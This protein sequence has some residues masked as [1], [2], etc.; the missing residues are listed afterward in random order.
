MVRETDPIGW[1]LL[2]AELEGIVQRGRETARRISA[3]PV[4]REM[5]ECVFALFTPTGQSVCYSEGL[6]LH[7]TSMGGAI[8]FMVENDYDAKVGIRPG[9]L[10]FNND[11]YISGAHSPDQMILTP[12]FA[13][14]ELIGWAGG[15]THVPEVGASEPGG[16]GSAS[17]SRYDEGIFMPCVKIGQDDQL[18]FDLE[19]LVERGTR[20]STWWLL[21]NRAKVAGITAIRDDLL[22]TIEKHGLE[23]YREATA[24]YIEATRDACRN[25]VRTMLEPGTYRAVAFYDVPWGDKPVRPQNDYL[26]RFAV[27]MVVNGD[28]TMAIDFEGTSAAG[29]HPSNCTPS[30]VRGLIVTVLMTSLFYDLNAN[31]GLEDYFASALKIPPSVLNPPDFSYATGYW[32]GVVP[33]MSAFRDC[34]T[35]AI[36]ARGYREECAGAYGI[37]CGL[38]TGGT[39]Q[40]GKTFSVRQFESACLGLPATA[41]SDGVDACFAIFN[42]N[43][44][45]S[46]A[47]VWEKLIPQMF[48]G[49]RVAIDGGGAGRFRGGSGIESLYFVYHVDEVEMGSSN[50]E[51]RVFAVPGMMGAYPASTNRRQ[52]MTGTNLAER[53][54]SGELPHSE[55]DDPQHPDWTRLLSGRPVVSDGSRFMEPFRKFDLWQQINGH[56]GGLGDPIDRDPTRVLA[57]VREGRVS[58]T[59]A[60]RVY[61]VEFEEVNEALMVDD[62]ATQ[63]LRKGIR[64]ERLQRGVPARE[65]IVR[66]RERLERGALPT[67]AKNALN[68]YFEHSSAFASEFREFWSLDEGFALVP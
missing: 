34:L 16:T 36:Y 8:K 47:E 67:P 4:V 21:D 56:S 32:T 17:S 68:A 44:D 1:Q 66:G 10:F 35:R 45:S 19:L 49:R 27:Q 12:I 51:S 43:G 41:A 38:G 57:D 3:S 29:R 7:V 28:G 2:W 64:A 31:Q 30:L 6:L 22:R 54:S 50:A 15:L 14:D 39:N 25:I 59:V 23:Y 63:R 20:Y 42:P 18:R 33:S 62:E 5:G 26:N 61:G 37:P 55:G 9:D 46:D 40:Y 24:E 60:K 11:P 53:L 52:L 48:L 65:F 13:G 58:R